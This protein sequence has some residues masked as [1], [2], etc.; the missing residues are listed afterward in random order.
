MTRLP[1]TER[2][3]CDWFM[4]VANSSGWTCYPETVFD[5]LVVHDKTGYQIGIEAKMALNAKVL[6]QTI[7]GYQVEGVG[8]DFLAVLVPESKCQKH[9]SE[10]A[11]HLNIT[12]IKCFGKPHNEMSYPDEMRN[13]F[14]VDGVMLP[15]FSPWPPDIIQHMHDENISKWMIDQNW[16]D[17]APDIQ[18]NLPEYV[19]K[20]C[21]GDKSPIKLTAWKIQAIKALIVLE[22]RGHITP[23]D[24]R[25]LNLSMSQW[26]NGWLVKGN[27]RGQWIAGDLPDFKYQLPANYQEIEDDFDNWGKCFEQ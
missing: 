18:V 16:F 11:K 5:I 24:F 13:F 17:L 12:V 22:K 14:T 6:L 26:R 21:A 10:L 25:K 2:Q 15:V 9:L 1:E 27:I 4:G 8:P 7:S 3:L 23:A 20:V 19:P